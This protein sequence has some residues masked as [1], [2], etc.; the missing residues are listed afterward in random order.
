MGGLLKNVTIKWV[1]KRSVRKSQ[2]SQKRQFVP[3]LVH[4]SAYL[5]PFCRPHNCRIFAHRFPTFTPLHRVVRFMILLSNGA[6]AQRQ[7]R[8]HPFFATVLLYPPGAS[9]WIKSRATGISS[10]C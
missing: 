9:S 7:E 6:Q 1:S 8:P 3:L 10:G 5:C 2:Q 4:F